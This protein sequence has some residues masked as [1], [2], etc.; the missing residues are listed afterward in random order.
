MNSVTIKQAT[1]YIPGKM[2]WQ[3]NHMSTNC[4]PWIHVEYISSSLLL[5][6]T[7]IVDAICCVSQQMAVT[8]CRKTVH[9]EQNL[10]QMMPFHVIPTLFTHWWL[11]YTDWLRTARPLSQ[12]T[13][14]IKTLTIWQVQTKDGARPTLEGSYLT[15]HQTAKLYRLFWTRYHLI[16]RN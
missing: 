14:P 6:I 12:N 8:E 5:S 1:C 2:H 16:I 7:C 9:L 11:L 4:L 13:K 15:E 3:G 10:V